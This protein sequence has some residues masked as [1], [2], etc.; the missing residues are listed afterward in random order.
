MAT[1]MSAAVLFWIIT[2]QRT[3]VANIKAGRSVDPA[4]G[5]RGKQRSV[6]NIYFTLPVLLAMR[7]NHYSFILSHPQNWLVLILMMF[8]GAANCQFFVVRHG[9]KPRPQTPAHRLRAGA[10][11]VG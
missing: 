5:I 1:A 7:S 11:T 9:N 4:Q 10:V 6:R 3:A 2:G 8:A